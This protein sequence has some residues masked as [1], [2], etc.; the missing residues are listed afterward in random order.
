MTFL[1]LV[2]LAKRSHRFKKKR[3]RLR[4][5]SLTYRFNKKEKLLRREVGKGVF[6]GTTIG[7]TFELVVTGSFRIENYGRPGKK[8]T[9]VRVH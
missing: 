7:L 6:R 9:E 5:L 1:N 3:G 8:R 4:I 2:F